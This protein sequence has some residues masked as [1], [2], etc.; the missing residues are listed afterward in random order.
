MLN[1]IDGPWTFGRRGKYKQ[2]I[3]YLPSGHGGH[4]D[5]ASVVV[6]FGW[7]NDPEAVKAARLICAAPEMLKAIRDALLQLE[8][9]DS[10][11]PTGTTPT[12]ITRINAV[13]NKATGEVS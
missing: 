9:I 7:Q 4:Y 10:K 13:I 12:I 3:D 2:F 5:F 11:F 6:Q 8:Y 1:Y